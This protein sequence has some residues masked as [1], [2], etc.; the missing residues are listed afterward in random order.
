VFGKA[1]I[2]R[3]CSIMQFG[4]GVGV[5]CVQDERP[6]PRRAAVGPSIVDWQVSGPSGPMQERQACSSRSPSDSQPSLQCS[7]VSRKRSF[8]HRRKGQIGTGRSPRGELTSP[9]RDEADLDASGC[10]TNKS[11]L[12]PICAGAQNDG[13]NSSICELADHVRAK[14]DLRDERS[15]TLRLP[16]RA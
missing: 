13:G 7:L 14:T 6:L 2:G 10:S 8:K 9:M 11:K 16:I 3:L 1:A 12:C 4:L 15:R 5:R